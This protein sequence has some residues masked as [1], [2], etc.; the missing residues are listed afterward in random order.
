MPIKD[1]RPEPSIPQMPVPV[2]FTDHFYTAHILLLCHHRGCPELLQGVQH[3][4]KKTQIMESV[5]VVR[6]NKAKSWILHLGH[7]N[8]LNGTF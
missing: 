7:N 6:F 1:T 4:Q 5:A 8:P 2:C 3:E